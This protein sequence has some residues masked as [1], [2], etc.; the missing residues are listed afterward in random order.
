MIVYLSAPS[1]RATALAV[2]KR[3]PDPNWSKP[4]KDK[5]NINDLHE[6]TGH[7]AL[8][9]L[10]DLAENFEVESLTVKRAPR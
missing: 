2:R 6:R 8:E 10:K 5:V 7:C 4:E 1:E 9:D 3:K